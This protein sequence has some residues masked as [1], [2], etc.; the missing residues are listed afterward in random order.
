MNPRSSLPAMPRHVRP[1]SARRTAGAAGRAADAG[2][3]GG[4][5]LA[6]VA[7]TLAGAVNTTEQGPL[8]KQGPLQ[9][10]KDVVAAGTAL[11]RTTVPAA[12]SALH[13]PGQEMP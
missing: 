12:K 3:G 5:A 13:A 7:V 4:A 9:P 11:S 10:E 6:N 2:S 1:P 8:P